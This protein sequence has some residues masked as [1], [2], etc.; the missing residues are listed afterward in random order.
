MDQNKA[1]YVVATVV[2]VKDGRY[3]IAQR[4]PK[5]KAFPSLWTLPGGRLE[6]TDYKN[7]PGTAH[8]HPQWYN[9]LEDL[10][11]RE[12]MEE[13]GLQI[14]NIKYLTNLAFIRPDGIPVVVISLF[15]D[16]AGGDIKLSDELVNHAWVTLEEARNYPLIE[17]IFEE[18]EMLD[19]HLK[20][21]VLGLWK[22]N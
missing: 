4:S 12:V 11:A 13:V 2:V 10:A 7:K 17:G 15:A 21:Q 19:S 1:H 18:L 9:V 3:L 16:H 8:S 22:R 6:V 5:E 14:K 20:G